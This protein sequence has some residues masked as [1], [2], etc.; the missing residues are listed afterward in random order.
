[1]GLPKDLRRLLMMSTTSYIIFIYIG[2][3]VNLYIWEQGHSIADVSWFNFCLFFSWAFAF[4]GGAKL[5]TRQSIRLLFG[6]SALSGGTAFLLLFFLH[7]DN[8]LLWIAMIGIPVG[9]MWGFFAV[10]HNF[11]ISSFGKGRD[12]ANYFSISTTITQILNMTVPIVSAQA[13]R[14][15]GYASS[16]II[17]L[18]FIA[19][20]LYVSRILPEITLKGIA[21]DGSWS[22]HMKYRNVFASPALKWLIPSCLATGIFLQFQGLFALLFTFSITHDKMIIALL[23]ALYTLSSLFALYLYKK[24]PLKERIWLYISVAILSVGFLIV[25][26]PVAPILVLSNILTTMG[27]FYF[28]T[29]W[30]SQQFRLLSGLS[31][32]HQSRVFVWRECLLCVSRCLMLLLVLPLSSFSGM[33]FIVLIALTIFCLISVPFFQ[34]K[35]MHEHDLESGENM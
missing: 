8:R 34:R 19:A 15:F 1:M 5:L 23:N 3:F 9:A 18:I 14:W 10:S 29:T 25:L 4:A 22:D 31:P 30:N 16:F 32:M 35:A 33:I 12:F 28:S 21:E 26:Y 6:L 24:I 27:L 17:M 13:I 20:M 2:I 11:S 7:L